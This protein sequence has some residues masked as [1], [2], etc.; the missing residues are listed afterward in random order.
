MH[1]E[2]IGSAE[3]KALARLN[4]LIAM[5][6]RL[7]STKREPPPGV[8]G[9]YRVDTQL[10]EQWATSAQSFLRRVF[11]EKS[12]QCQKF[13]E[14]AGG[15]IAASEAMRGQ[16]ILRAAA[17]DLEGGHLFSLR[18]LVQAELLDDFL[19]Q[20][21]YLFSAGYYQAA[22]VVAG[23]VLEDTLRNLCSRHSL[24]ITGRPKLDKMNAD[25]AKA[26]VSSK[27]VQKRITT[28][29]DLRN[30][31]A[32]GEWGSFES[33]DVGEMLKSVRRLAEEYGA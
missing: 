2:G 16:G 14:V 29:A 22:A 32:H 7:I 4:E 5:G 27:L 8:F 31:A 30:K 6:E 19:E 25:L 13:V 28:L 10:G 33:E 12:V 20:A 15:F 9:D 24:T 21:E 11:G 17:E 18:Q 23:C 26:G 1:T 3:A